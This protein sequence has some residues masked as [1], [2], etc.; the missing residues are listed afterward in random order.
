[1]D[2]NQAVT[3]IDAFLDQ[4]RK[5]NADWGATEIRVLPS[6]E[7]EDQP[8]EARRL[9]LLI[10]SRP[11]VY[12][13]YPGYAYV[14]GGTPEAKDP[15]VLTVPGPTLV[16]EKGERVAI[17]LVNESH[18][19]AAVHWHGI[20]LESWPDGVPGWS[21]EG[22]RVLPAIPPG[23]SLTVRFT[24]P[25]A[26]TFMYH[27][28]FNEMQQ[29]G[30]GMYGAIVVLDSGATYASAT[31]RI[32]LVSDAGPTVN[33]IRG[34]FPPIA[35]NGSP[36][37]APMALVAGTRYRFRIINIRAEGM[38]QLALLSGGAPVTWRARTAS[39]S[40][41]GW[42]TQPCATWTIGRVAYSARRTIRSARA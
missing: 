22:E 36:S 3:V 25:R 30:S 16:L 31:D 37:P 35:L 27:S 28:H 38:A 18:E 9:R 10:R 5:A 7:P 4:F 40:G 17:T 14:L 11:E 42:G 20:E 32:L 21:G 23:D 12:G 13:K 2:I 34:P 24:P 26:G 29:L 19:S 1:M 6:G 41:S 39:T 33:V 15:D 8:P